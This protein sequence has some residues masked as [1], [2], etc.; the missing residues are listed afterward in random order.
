MLRNIHICKSFPN[1]TFIISKTFTKLSKICSTFLHCYEGRHLDTIQS[2]PIHPPIAL[3]PSVNCSLESKGFHDFLTK[4]HQEITFLLMLVVAGKLVNS[5]I[6]HYN[7]HPSQLNRIQKRSSAIEYSQKSHLLQN[8][9]YKN[10]PTFCPFGFFYF[11]RVLTK[12]LNCI[13]V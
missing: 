8:L 6:M 10:L 1:L 7:R 13:L 9:F 12:I 2:H 4:T 3:H 5:K 11:H